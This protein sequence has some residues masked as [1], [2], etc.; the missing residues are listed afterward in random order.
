MDEM[1]QEE[2]QKRYER[3]PQAVK[4]VMFQEA[5]IDKIEEL[6]KKYGLL[7]DKMGALSDEIALFMVGL[8]HPNDFRGRIRQALGLSD[9]KASE[10]VEELNDSIFKPIREQLAGLHRPEEIEVPPAPP[11][12][13]SFARQPI[14]QTPT[15]SSGSAPIPKPAT[16]PPIPATTIPPTAPMLPTSPTTTPVIF[17]SSVPAATPVKREPPP[18][19]RPGTIINDPYR[20]PVE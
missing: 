6:G 7:L 18:A 12:P 13:P 20:E 3:L 19:P 17:P 2:I 14:T 11:P 4:D 1:S 15:M 9:M 5:T 10:I 16:P 8:T